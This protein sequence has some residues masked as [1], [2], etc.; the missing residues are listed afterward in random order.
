MKLVK[1]FKR[2][3]AGDLSAG[4]SVAFVGIP[5]SMA[6]AE[7]AGLPPQYGLLAIS[8]GCLVTAPIVSSHYLQTGPVALVA[9]LTFGV[10]ASVEESDTASRIKRAALLAVLS[11]LIMLALGIL[12]FGRAVYL[13]SEPVMSGFIIGSAVLVIAAQL[14]KTVGMGA[15][16]QGV[17][18]SAVTV[19]IQPGE[20]HWGAVGL[21]A[22]TAALVISS[23]RVHKYFP[24]VLV[25]LIFSVLLVH[26]G[27]YSGST[28]A[29]AVHASGI[30]IRASLQLPWSST[31][32]LLIPAGVIALAGFAET[33][34]IS[35]PVR[36]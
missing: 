32:D 22:A 11:G 3:S 34:S 23:K 8:I 35:R 26:F 5:Q 31:P 25:A 19:L 18:A 10:I 30:D 1:S 21:A 13:L 4:V 7:L 14:P 2:P 6:Y 27:Y 36:C 16:D 29:D 28:L 17:L 20:W 33:S 15:V 12:R 9:L 24:G